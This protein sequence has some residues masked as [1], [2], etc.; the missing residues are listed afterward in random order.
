MRYTSIKALVRIIRSLADTENDELRQTC[1]SCLVICQENETNLNVLEAIKVAQVKT[2]SEEM[3]HKEKVYI[4]NNLNANNQLINQNIFCQMARKFSNIIKYEN[5]EIDRGEN[6]DAKFKSRNEA[7]VSKQTD[8]VSNKTDGNT[9][10]DE[11]DDGNL[12]SSRSKLLDLSTELGPVESKS[13]NFNKKR[14]TLK[15]EITISEQYSNKV[16]S[17]NKRKNFDLLRIVEDQVS[18]FA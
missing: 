17:Y 14:T 6:R 2:R 13:S 9:K 11:I 16:P 5:D 18:Y 7:S 12:L 8:K 3:S 1:W 4:N 15:D 10:L